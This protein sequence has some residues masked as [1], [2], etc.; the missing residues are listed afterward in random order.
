MTKM[1][2]TVDFECVNDKND[3]FACTVIMAEYPSGNIHDIKKFSCERDDTLSDPVTREF[4]R[5][6]IVAYHQ[7]I[8]EGQ[9]KVSHDEELELCVH[10]TSMIKQFPKIYVVLDNPQ[11]DNRLLDNIL[12]AHN[13]PPIAVRPGNTYYQSVCTWS[14]K[15]GVFA[16]LGRKTKDLQI[17]LNELGLNKC[18]DVDDY[19]GVR[20]TPQA[21]CARILSEHFKV[22][23]I[24]GAVH[25][26]PTGYTTG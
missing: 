25:L 12:Q 9:G 8:S 2:M 13:F 11:Y 15:M 4:W 24:I 22:M 17:I 16:L 6:N 5:R 18:R 3:W 23:D 21:D 19:F 14:F 20:H 26:R 7:L 10:V 1:F